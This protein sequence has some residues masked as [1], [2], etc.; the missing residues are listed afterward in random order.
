MKKIYLSVI[1]LVFI[2]QNLCAQVVG[3]DNVYEFLNLSASARITGLGGNLIAVRDDDVALAFNNPSL[4]NSSMG[5]QI[6]FGNNFYLS[7]INH[8][9]VSYGHYAK[10]WDLT[11]HGG[12]QYIS[13]GDFQATDEVGNVTGQFD[14]GEYAFTVG[15]GKELYERLSVGANLKFI[16]SQFESYNSVGM[17]ADLAATFHDTSRLVTVALV[18]KNI[19]TQFSTYTP[20]NRESVPYE[21]QLGVSKRLRHLPFRISVIYRYFNKWNILFDD[22]NSQEDIF[23]FG[24]DQ[25]AS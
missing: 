6:G 4:L 3:G 19:G 2:F 24:N 23:F 13:Y 18:F 21:M 20:G 11:W 22:P 1:L 15:A 14:A 7:D 17:V 5:G 8:G 16:T 25:T 12:V 9:Y 10:K